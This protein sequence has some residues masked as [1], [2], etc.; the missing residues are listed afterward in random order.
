MKPMKARDLFKKAE[1]QGWTLDRIEGSHHVF[2]KQGHQVSILGPAN[3]E[4][5]A[6]TVRGIL[7][8]MKEVSDD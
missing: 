8:K 1:A 2:V 7:K 6:G 4:V 3:N 5:P